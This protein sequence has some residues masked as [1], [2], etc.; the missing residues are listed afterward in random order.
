MTRAKRA[1]RFAVREVE[2]LC[3]GKFARIVRE[4]SEGGNHADFLGVVQESVFSRGIVARVAFR[5]GEIWDFPCKQ[6]V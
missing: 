3:G 4:V 5:N 2:R 1:T 6:V